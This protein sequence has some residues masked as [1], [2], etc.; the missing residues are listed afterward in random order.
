MALSNCAWLILIIY[1]NAYTFTCTSFWHSQFNVLNASGF[2]V[3]HKGIVH[4]KLKM[5]H[6]LSLMSFETS[7]CFLFL[8]NDSQ[9]V[10]GPHWLSFMRVSKLWNTFNLWVNYPFKSKILQC[11]SRQLIYHSIAITTVRPIGIISIQTPVLHFP[12]QCLGG[13][14]ASFRVHGYSIKP[15]PWHA[16]RW[17]FV[18]SYSVR[19]DA[20]SK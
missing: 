14:L 15:F 18:E 3:F 7:R 19:A 17:V 6:L 20:L 2:G 16:Q 8:C 12:W 5:H 9:C 13:E 1:V 11:T 10:V 4:P